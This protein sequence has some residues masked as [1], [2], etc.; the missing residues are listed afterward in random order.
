MRLM[1]KYLDRLKRLADDG[2]E[3]SEQVQIILLHRAEAYE[4]GF[5]DGEKKGGGKAHFGP[6][7]GDDHDKTR[8]KSK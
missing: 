5:R 6:K 7:H 4:E 3:V 2:E 8:S 1:N